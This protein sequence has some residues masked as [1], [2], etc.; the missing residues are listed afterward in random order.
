MADWEGTGWA[1]HPRDARM[2]REGNG[3]REPA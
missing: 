2:D 1:I 3:A